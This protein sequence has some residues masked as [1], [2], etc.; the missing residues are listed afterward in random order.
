MATNQTEHYSLNQWELSDSV[1]M[2][3]FNAD[4]QKLDS[5]LMALSQKIDN[6]IA[7]LP[8]IQAG[9]YTGTGTY[10]TDNPNTL[11]FDFTPKLVII[12]QYSGD[13]DNGGGGW[14]RL[15]AVHGTT[16]CYSEWSTHGQSSPAFINLT[17]SE[18]SLSW[19]CGADAQR[20]GN[21]AGITYHYIA[22]G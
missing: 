7:N 1:V 22:I 6:V 18:H 10:G 9:S 21:V 3:D 17:W 15:I 5:A 4:N 14:T 19:C 12:N 2:A 16:K 13:T 8:R 11:T 20:Q